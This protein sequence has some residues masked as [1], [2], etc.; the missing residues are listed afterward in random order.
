MKDMAIYGDSAE[1]FFGQELLI[2]YDRTLGAAA[3][4]GLLRGSKGAKRGAKVGAGVSILTG[5]QQISIPAGTVLEFTLVGDLV[6][7]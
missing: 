2:G 1:Y 4:G 6:I 5:G 7:R 3:I